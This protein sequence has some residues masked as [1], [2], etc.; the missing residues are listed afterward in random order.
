MALAFSMLLATNAPVTVLFTVCLYVMISVPATPPL[1][2][3]MTVLG[4]GT[5]VM[6]PKKCAAVNPVMA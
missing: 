4:A 3:A 2:A 5:H 1:L 6:A